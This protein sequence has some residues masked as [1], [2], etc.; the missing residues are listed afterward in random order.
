MIDREQALA[1]LRTY[2]KAEN[3][4]NHALSVEAVMRRFA[5]HYGEDAQYWGLIGLLHD[6]DYELYPDQ[7]CQMAPAL[8]EKGGV[9]Q[10]M[11]R[12]IVSHGWGICSDVEPVKKV[13]KVLY[14]IDELTG[15]IT[16]TALMR[17]SKS[18]HDLSVKSV[19]KKWKTKGFSAGVDR[20]LIQ[21]GCDMLPME[22]N[23][24]IQLS[25]EGMR[26]VAAEIGLEGTGSE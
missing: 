8:L 19:I 21:K 16:A 1:L 11:I 25:I 3:L 12:A 2:N 9:D 14:T 20:D 5:E 18:L 15:L 26:T 23:E 7:H 4:I 10:E 22:R 17:P 13:E 6:I 24:V